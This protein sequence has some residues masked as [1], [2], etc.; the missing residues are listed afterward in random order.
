MHKCDF[1]E[2]DSGYIL[3]PKYVKLQNMAGFSICERSKYARI[4]IDRVLN[5]S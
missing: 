3:G 5:L 4:F 1:N 2:Q